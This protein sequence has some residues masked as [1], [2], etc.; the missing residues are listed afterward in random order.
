MRISVKIL[1]ALALTAL[2]LACAG[3]ESE[4]EP[5]ARMS[6]GERPSIVLVVLD[7]VRRDVTGLGPNLGT[8]TDEGASATP[9]LDRLAEAGTSFPHAWAPAPWT[10]PSHASIFTGEPPSVHGGT[11]RTPHLRPELTTLAEILATEGY[12]TAAFFSNPWLSDGASG[13]LRGFEERFALAEDP[14]IPDQG[15]HA[16]VGAVARWLDETS[17]ST[18]GTEPFFLFV[19]FLEAH[20]PYASPPRFREHL[21]GLNAGD[22]VPIDWILDFQAGRIDPETVDWRRYRDLYSSDVLYADAFLGQLVGL[23]EERGLLSGNALLVTSDHGENLGEHGF[24]EHQFRI[25]ETLL[26]VPLVVHAP[27][28]L[29]P[30]ERRDPVDLADLFATILD[31]VGS[32]AEAPPRSR[33]LLGPPAD[34][35]RPLVAQYAGPPPGL[36]DHLGARHAGF[37]RASRAK[38][39]RSLRVGPL[40][41]TV[42]DAGG[43]TLHDLEADPGQTE[44]LAKRRPEAV[45]AMQEILDELAG[46]ASGGP[47]GEADG[48]APELDEATRERLRALGYIR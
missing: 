43:V 36:L 31:L 45:A 32:D 7:T 13:V 24:V 14:E 28:H 3:G 41:L 39:Y 48:D 19:N 20:S 35:R 9:H 1:E 42:D 29:A 2:V 15:G 40:R 33:S 4:R 37:D 16:I 11:S 10:V 25:D 22:R 38:S 26:A 27:A 34:P 8:D 18:S 47:F 30:G 17:Q 12:R 46:T 21:P 44:N 5:S 6:S 23:L